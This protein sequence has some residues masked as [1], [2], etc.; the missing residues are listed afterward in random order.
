[1]TGLKPEDIIDPD[2]A[3]K[4]IL[5]PETPT[6]ERLRALP[7]LETDEDEEAQDAIFRLATGAPKPAHWREALLVRAGGIEWADPARQAAIVRA[8]QKE[9]TKILGNGRRANAKQDDRLCAMIQQSITRGPLPLSGA[10]INPLLPALRSPRIA[11]RTGA[12]VGILH[13]SVPTPAET[14]TIDPAI[15]AELARHTDGLLEEAWDAKRFVHGLHTFLAA[16]LLDAPTIGHLT[17]ERI[18]TAKKLALERCSTELSAFL[19]CWIRCN[20]PEPRR[21]R[22]AALAASFEAARPAFGVGPLAGS[23]SFFFGDLD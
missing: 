16:A 21:A 13:A 4:L 14:E 5:N 22:L 11:A 19:R 6:K 2:Q 20:A 3:K 17:P 1:M 9:T 7:W 10:T 23:H 12:F 15:H 8:L 18:G